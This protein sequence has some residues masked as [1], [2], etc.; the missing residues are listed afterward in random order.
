MKN[1][2]LAYICLVALLILSMSVFASACKQEGIV[3]EV[4]N[5]GQA[6]AET[7]TAAPAAQA[8]PQSPSEAP[9]Q[10]QPADQNAPSG[11]AS[12]QAAPAQNGE[13][14][15]ASEGAAQASPAAP[16]ETGPEPNPESVIGQLSQQDREA[17]ITWL[18]GVQ[19]GYAKIGDAFM[20]FAEQKSSL[21]DE[22]KGGKTIAQSAAFQNL[23]TAVT[24]GLDEVASFGGENLPQSV[25]VLYE[26]SQELNQF[27]RDFITSFEGQTATDAAG[28]KSWLDSKIN[29]GIEKMQAF[30]TAIAGLQS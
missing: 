18:N 2:K 29:E 3:I 16:S 9:Q 7:T 8:A 12:D 13:S 25:S 22:L 1:R 26:K 21:I 20:Q 14:T 28:I 23:K 4:S 30:I 5:P 19:A 15:P 11:S 6:A 10:S 24:A 17:V 27:F